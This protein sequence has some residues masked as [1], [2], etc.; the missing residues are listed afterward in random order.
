M[1]VCVYESGPSEV[2][3]EDFVPMLAG[4]AVLEEEPDARHALL[5]QLLGYACTRATWSYVCAC[6]CVRVQ[7]SFE[8]EGAGTWRGT[9][10]PAGAR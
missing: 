5:E 8:C 4:A 9:Y 10:R 1:C 6:A 7:A 3:H 2:G